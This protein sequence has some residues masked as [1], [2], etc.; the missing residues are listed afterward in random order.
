[1]KSARA[2]TIRSKINQAQRS[3]SI[4]KRKEGARRPNIELLKNVPRSKQRWLLN[5][6]VAVRSV[7]SAK[8]RNE[9]LKRPARERNN[10]SRPNTSCSCAS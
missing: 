7:R 5:K 2:P 3:R 10:E 9:R 4:P 8:R 6:S 1:M